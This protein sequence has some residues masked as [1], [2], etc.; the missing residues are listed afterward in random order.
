MMRQVAHMKR[1][2]MV[3]LSPAVL[4]AA[5]AFVSGVIDAVYADKLQ[6]DATGRYLF[7]DSMHIGDKRQMYLLDVSAIVTATR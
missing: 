5:C 2:K 1:W 7:I 4:S 6:F 3:V